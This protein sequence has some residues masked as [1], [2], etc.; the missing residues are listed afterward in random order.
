M[1]VVKPFLLVRGL[2][3]L[4]NALYGWLGGLL[5]LLSPYW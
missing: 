3:L 2:P 4:F 1:L 5:L